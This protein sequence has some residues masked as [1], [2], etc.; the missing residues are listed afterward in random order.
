MMA[1]VVRSVV[2]AVAGVVLLVLV[3]ES[4]LVVVVEASN[5]GGAPCSVNVQCGWP[6]ANVDSLREG[7]ASITGQCLDGC[8]SATSHSC[9]VCVVCYT[10]HPSL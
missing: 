6:A 10:V 3:L 9:F 4:V 8:V 1:C 5:K 2:P 7:A